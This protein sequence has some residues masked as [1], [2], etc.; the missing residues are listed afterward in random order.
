[1][2]TWT[3]WPAG[4]AWVPSCDWQGLQRHQCCGPW[5]PGASTP[6]RDGEGQIESG[7]DTVK[8]K[9]SS[10]CVGEMC[11]KH[12]PFLR[13]LFHQLENKRRRW[14]T[15]LFPWYSVSHNLRNPTT[16]LQIPNRSLISTSKPLI[17]G[18]VLWN[19]QH[20]WVR[21]HMESAAQAW[22]GKSTKKLGQL[23]SSPVSW[24]LELCEDHHY[25]LFEK[26][27]WVSTAITHFSRAIGFNLFQHS[28][29]VKSE[30]ANGPSSTVV[31]YRVSSS[32]V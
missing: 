28:N 18:A 32:A 22:H 14:E 16:K 3:S 20:R 1:M 19:N 30:G 9:A 17:W 5:L 13:P 26:S 15:V 23:N 4:S 31:F 2:P 12:P 21:I 8:S 6:L 27:I 10:V 24:L 25:M 29:S 7:T 11:N